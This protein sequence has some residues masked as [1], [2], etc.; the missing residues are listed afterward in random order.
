MLNKTINAQLTVNGDFEITVDVQSYLV[1]YNRPQM[2][3]S[4]KKTI[5]LPAGYEILIGGKIYT[6]P[7]SVTLNVDDVGRQTQRAGQNIYLYACQGTSTD[8]V[9]KLSFNSTVPDG[10]NENN[11]RK[12]GG[13]HCLCSDVGTIANHLLSGYVAGD[14]LPAT[15]WDLIHRPRGQME[16]MA[17]DERTD[18]WISIYLL[19]WDGSKLVSTN[20]GVVADGTSSK[21]WHAELFV[22]ELAKL[23]MRLPH[24]YEFQVAAKG[25]NEET[26]IKNSA[27][28]NTTGNHFDTAN[29]RMISNLGLEDCCGFMWQ[30]TEDIGANGGTDWAD[31]VY[32]SSVDD[33]RYGGSYGSL[34]RPLVGGN[35]SRGSRCGSRSVGVGYVSASVDSGIG[36]RGACEPFLKNALERK[37]L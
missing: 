22:E 26:N 14:I 10:Y 17:Y 2:F 31:S 36:A 33:K 35:W 27:D 24:R 19:S 20:N 12:I 15:C 37:S 28:V 1:D 11:S 13:F 23:K 5:I 8:I 30:W 34:Y 9:F 18:V 7:N 21:K 29:R 32:N 25:S 3:T 4:T 16:A 6:N